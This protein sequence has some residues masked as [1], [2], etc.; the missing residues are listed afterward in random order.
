MK[1]RY[2]YTAKEATNGPKRELVKWQN[3]FVDRTSD[4]I[5]PACQKQF[6]ERTKD[7]LPKCAEDLTVLKTKEQ[8]INRYNRKDLLKLSN[9]MNRH[10]NEIRRTMRDGLW[11]VRKSVSRRVSGNQC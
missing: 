2:I 11:T 7:P 3:V 1:L 10:R 6:N 9:T 8:V 5:Q 4:K